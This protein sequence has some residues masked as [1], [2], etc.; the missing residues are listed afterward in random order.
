[1][2]RARLLGESLVVEAASNDGYLLQVYREAGVPVLGIEPAANVAEVARRA[3]HPDADASSSTR[4]WRGPLAAR[5]GGPTSSTPTTC[6]P[7]S[8]T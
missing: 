5:A 4:A 6:S 2:V 8:P 7:T 3:G 1:M